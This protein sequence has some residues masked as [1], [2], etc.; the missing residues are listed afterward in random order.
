MKDLSAV[1]NP[2]NDDKLISCCSIFGMMSVEGRG[3]NGTDIMNAIAN[4]HDR[5]NGLGGGFAVYGLYPEYADYYAFHVMYLHGT[6]R[7]QVETLLGE[8][9]KIIKSERIPTRPIETVTDP[10]DIWRYFVESKP[11]A[12]DFLSEDDYVVHQVMKINSGIDGAYVFSCGKNMGVFKGVGFPEDIGRFFRLEE[13]EAYLWTAHGRFPTNSQAWWG[14]AHPFSILDWTVVHNGEISSYGTNRRFLEM[15]GYTCTMHTDTE[16]IAYAV[17]LLA[18]RHGLSVE[19]MAKV[20]SPPM[21]SMLPYMDP[22]EQD[23]CRALRQVYS[24]LLMNGPFTIIIAHEGQMIGL[25]DR[26]RLRPLVAGTKDDILYLSSEEAAIRLISPQLDECWS[27]MGGEAIIGTLG[28]PLTRKTPL[29]V[30]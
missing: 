15:F 29:A 9:F 8:T 17:D 24:G 12:E 7:Q 14:G 4:M 26:V 6:A 1:N 28:Q 22:D 2:Y 3:F 21:W 19:Q 25:T 27:P 10:P 18:R 23:V 30:A 13:Y 11:H 16:V 20:L 5:G